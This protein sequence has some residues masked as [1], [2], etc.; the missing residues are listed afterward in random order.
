MIIRILTIVCGIAIIIMAINTKL[1]KT[2]KYIA[3]LK[4]KYVESSIPRY[5]KL[6]TY[7]QFF[8]GSGLIV[9]GIF[10]SG[11]GYIIGTFICLLGVILLIVG[12]K[13]LKKKN[14]PYRND[15]K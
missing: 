1:D 4:E 3:P 13:G 12:I 6:M 7:A 8:F 2:G 5:L 14:V 11:I 10:G 9:Q 15:K